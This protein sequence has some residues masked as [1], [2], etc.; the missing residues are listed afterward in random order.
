MNYHLSSIFI[1]EEFTYVNS[2]D[3]P[4]H[5]FAE[6]QHDSVATTSTKTILTVEEIQ[7]L[8]PHRYPFA[9]M[10]DQI[11][12]YVPRQRAVGI[13][14]VTFN[15]PYFQ[16]HFP[17]RPIMP[18]ATASYRYFTPRVSRFDRRG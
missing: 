5:A 12:E 16:G 13:K 6:H 1:F 2:T 17:R 9:I 11:I 18:G 10:V 7:K 8:L 4:V 3:S 14:N 15:E